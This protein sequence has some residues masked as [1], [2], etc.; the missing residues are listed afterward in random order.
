MIKARFDPKSFDAGDLT[1]RSIKRVIFASHTDLDRN[2]RLRNPFDTGFS[3]SSWFAQSNGAPAQHPNPPTKGG[4]GSRGASDP[5]VMMDSIGATL[6][7]ANSAAY[8][9]K[10]NEGWSPQAPAGW[11]DACANMYQDFIQIHT[12]RERGK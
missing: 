4:P 1:M 8:I 7:L 10:L 12:M 5:N 11:I 2:L 3:A 6:T 9:G